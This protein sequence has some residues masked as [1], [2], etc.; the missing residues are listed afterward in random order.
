MFFA[1]SI[2]NNKLKF[3]PAKQKYFNSFFGRL[4]LTIIQ[5]PRVFNVKFFFDRFE[6]NI[7][8]NQLFKHIV[9]SK[10]KAEL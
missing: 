1:K 4:C 6:S 5:T 7:E 3:F 10:L 2:L 9:V 8:N